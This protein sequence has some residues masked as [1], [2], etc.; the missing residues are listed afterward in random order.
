[1]DE[2]GRK[3]GL[4]GFE[5]GFYGADSVVEDENGEKHYFRNGSE[6]K[7]M[8]ERSKGIQMGV[9]SNLITDMTLQGATDEELARAVRH[10]M[11]VI[12]AVKH[13]LDYKRSEEE[14]GI[15]AL[16]KEF[17][18]GGGV[19]TLITKAKSDK[20]VDRHVGEAHVNKK[21][22]P[23]IK[24]IELINEDKIR[25]KLLSNDVNITFQESHA[26]RYKGGHLR[27]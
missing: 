3:N 14:N 19:S 17:Q 13:K 8:S 11:V 22:N 21:G 25:A 24:D 26:L 12:D 9:V 7:L 5:T 15:A 16:K 10:S 6:F 20:Y 23:L 4:K 27:G 1:M 2:V 18:R